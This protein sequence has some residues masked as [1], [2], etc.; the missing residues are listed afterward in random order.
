M[1]VNVPTIE[2]LNRLHKQLFDD[3]VKL[4]AAQEKTPK[5]LTGREVCKMLHLSVGKLKR[6]RDSGEIEFIS[7]GKKYLYELKHIL[8]IIERN[9]KNK[10]LMCVLYFLLSAYLDVDVLCA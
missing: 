2:D 4:F 10:G 8:E 6:M 7:T 3:L 9:K 1:N 5:F